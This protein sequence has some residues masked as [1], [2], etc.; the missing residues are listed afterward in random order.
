[1]PVMAGTGAPAQQAAPPPPAPQPAAPP[2]VVQPLYAQPPYV[3]APGVGQP[4]VVQPPAV[5]YG[6]P[7][8]QPPVIGPQPVP[9]AWPA[10]AA[11]GQVKPKSPMVAALL[12]FFLGGFG[13]QAFYNGQIKKGAIQ[14]VVF[15]IVWL[16]FLPGP[17]YW[18]DT[19]YLGIRFVVGLVFAG[20]C[21]ADG[22]KIAEKRNS[23]QPVAEFA[24][25]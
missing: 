6:P 17:Q 22:Y 23:G 19:S 24:S 16:F 10:A 21:A 3:Q 15:W 18:G 8:Y 9:G 2:P 11:V 12:G 7:Q 4:P 13:A 25:F 14:L 20:A 1:M 5:G